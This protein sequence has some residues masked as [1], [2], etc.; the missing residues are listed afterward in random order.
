MGAGRAGDAP[1]AELM[2]S[3]AVAAQE[4]L[5]A[6]HIHEGHID[7]LGGRRLFGDQWRCGNE[8]EDGDGDGDEV[9]RDKTLHILRDGP[10]RLSWKVKP[11]AMVGTKHSFPPRGRRGKGNGGCLID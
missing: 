9:G 6:H 2:P 7:G 10:G 1:L 11:M 3:A 5:R 4:R 8:D